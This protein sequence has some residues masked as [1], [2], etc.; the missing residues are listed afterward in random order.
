MKTI[1]ENFKATNKEIKVLNEIFEKGL[2]LV[3]KI[4]LYGA[5]HPQ[6]PSLFMLKGNDFDKEKFFDEHET[7]HAR[8]ACYNSIEDI[9]NDKDFWRNDFISEGQEFDRIDCELTTYNV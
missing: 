4:K 8:F 3:R 5:A 9:S 6:L 2:T 1:N 7:T